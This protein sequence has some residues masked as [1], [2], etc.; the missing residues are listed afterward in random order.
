M[1]K[2]ILL[3]GS[4]D[5]IGLETA[6]ALAASHHNVLLHGRSTAK[7]DDAETQ[8]RATGGRGVIQTYQAD[9]SRADDVVALAA[10]VTGEHDRLDVIVNNAGVFGV[11]DPKADN[12]LDVR[13]MVNTVAPYILTQRLLPLLNEDG[14]VINLSSAAQASVDA[15]AFRGKT[16]LDDGSAYAQSKLAI[17][18]WSIHLARQLGESGPS[19]IA[20]NPGSLLGTKMVREAFGTAGKDI[21]IGVDILTRAATSDEF[22]NASGRYWDND[23]QHFANPHPDALDPQKNAAL[24]ALLE[25][26]IE[27]LTR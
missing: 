13:F 22:A 20:V 5:G 9:L 4:T 11:S 1:T 2:T 10:A 18:M 12:G 7:L 26:T 17:T 27:S 14:R 23:A 8:V 3:T 15:D 16:Q 6:K 24:V 21:G 25:T 19:I